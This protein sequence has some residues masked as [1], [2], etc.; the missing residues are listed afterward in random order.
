MMQQQHDVTMVET[1]A[2][3]PATT[4]NPTADGTA[5]V[6]IVQSGAGLQLIQQASGSSSGTTAP[7]A[8]PVTVT[9]NPQSAFLGTLSGIAAA[10]TPQPTPQLDA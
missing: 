8:M 3:T 9:A 2:T 7:V 10:T 6:Q 4:A 5:T 1:D